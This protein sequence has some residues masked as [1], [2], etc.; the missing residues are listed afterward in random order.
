MSLETL[1]PPDILESAPP[2]PKVGRAPA[3]RKPRF[4]NSENFQA[5]LKR[6]VEEYFQTTGKSKRDSVSLYV[7]A[8]VIILWLAASYL[9][10]VFL[11]VPLWGVI[12]LSLSLALAAAGVGFNIQHDGGHQAF[13]EKKIVNKFTAF[14]LDLLGGSSYIWNHKHNINHHSFANIHGHDDDFEV[15][16]LARMCPHQKHYWFHRF[17]HYY[18]WI[19]YGFIS[20]KW[21]LFD[22]FYN[23]A[24]AKIGEAPFPR[25]KGR[26]LMLFVV[27]KIFFFTLVFVI[28]SFYHPF[29]KV[30][31]F[32]AAIS[33]TQGVVLAVIFQLA[34]VVEEADFPLPDDATYR[35][36]NEWMIHQ[37]E[38]TVD[39]SQKN[40]LITWFAGGLN[41]QVEHHLFPRISHVHY[42]ELAKIV[43]ATC[44]EFGVQYNTHK[45]FWSSLRSHFRLLKQLGRAK[46]EG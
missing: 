40:P 17:Q 37:I 33:F 46:A 32:Y 43:E 38:T 12:L 25:P 10:L 41:Y 14:T 35:M 36:E 7:K 42:P 1:T 18:M 21:Q 45:T 26:D 20:L 16:P 39:F 22:D 5:T 8:A 13:S 2:E 3:H 15:G 34:H 28:P 30:A 44:K 4:P 24:K 19:L 29:W 9:M 31:L 6:R 23:L 27:G 11:P